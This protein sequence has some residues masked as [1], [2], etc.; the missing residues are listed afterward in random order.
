MN[1]FN[2][3]KRAQLGLPLANY[4]PE[5]WAYPDG[6]R[7]DEPIHAGDSRD[8]EVALYLAR[9]EFAVLDNP[10]LAYLREDGIENL[11]ARESLDWLDWTQT[12]E[13]IR[14]EWDFT[15]AQIEHARR[16]LAKLAAV[17]A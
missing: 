16:V 15:P 5:P 8:H 13:G 6:C 1:G 3:G 10:I 17:Y 14:D 2:S 7:E 9:P 11:N 4:D 12:D